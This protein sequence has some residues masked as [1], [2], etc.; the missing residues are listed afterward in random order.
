MCGGFTPAANPATPEIQAMVNGLKSNVEGSMGKTTEE[1]VAICY[2]TQVVAGLNYKVKV[3][4]DGEAYIHVK[5]FEPLPHTGQ[6]PSV[7]GVE[8]G[9]TADSPL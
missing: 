3:K 7:S 1:Y 9:M 5:I 6:F 4:I 8:Q 2:K